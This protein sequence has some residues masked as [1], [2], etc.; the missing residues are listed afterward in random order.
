MR[1]IIMPK[2]DIDSTQMY[3]QISNDDT[4]KIQCTEKYPPYI[5][6]VAEGNEPE[7]QE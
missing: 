4:K 6:W 7:E 3:L 1:Y 2:A 5:E